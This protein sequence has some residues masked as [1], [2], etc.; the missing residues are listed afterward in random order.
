MSPSLNEL[1][2]GNRKTGL[3]KQ[4]N[5]YAQAQSPLIQAKK[6]KLTM[7]MQIM[8]N[9]EIT[10]IKTVLSYVNHGNLVTNA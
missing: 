3:C 2:L 6:G 5:I 10:I 4:L 7:R 1:L 9:K 8:D